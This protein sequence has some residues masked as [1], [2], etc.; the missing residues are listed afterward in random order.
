MCDANCATNDVSMNEPE[1]TPPPASVLDEPAVAA[2]PP[3]L[4][5]V[6]LWQAIAGMS[7]AIALAT[8]IVTT[9]L[10]KS[11]AARTNYMNRRIAALNAT[12]RDL[13]RQTS[14]AKLKLGAEQERAS[15]RAV[16]EKILFAPDL[17]TIKLGSPAEK[18]KPGAQSAGAS[19]PTGRL[20][21]SQ[22]ANGAMLDASG[23]QPTGNFQ[24][25]RIWWTPKRGAPVWAA[26]FLVGED[27][28]ARVAVDLPPAHLKDPSLTVTLEDEA[29]SE[30]PAGP[31]ALKGDTAR[32]EAKPSSQRKTK[33][34]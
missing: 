29:Y 22:S 17:R 27:G 26:D 1:S 7:A 28:A 12:M 6:K 9:E 33:R 10:A 31:V 24:V 32:A 18:S 16:F 5:R 30:L 20:A 23:L 21:M 3:R 4:G 13:K 25:Y 15:E 14:A 11:L 19:L 34:Q 8:T 2:K